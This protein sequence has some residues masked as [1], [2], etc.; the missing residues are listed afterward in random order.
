MIK[1]AKSHTGVNDYHKTIGWGKRE[2]SINVG[3]KKRRLDIAD[4]IAEKGIE[5]KEYSSGKV[6]NSVD[7]RNE[8]EL[9]KLL[10]DDDWVIEWMFKGCSPSGPLETSLKQAGI[11]INFFD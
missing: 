3:G 5:V 9:D 7:I 4:E 6:Y 1:A 2:V 10:V 11:I 8:V